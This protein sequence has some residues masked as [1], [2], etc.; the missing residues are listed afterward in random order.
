[1]EPEVPGPASRA[2]QAAF[3]R[4]A[5]RLALETAPGRVM[6]ALLAETVATVGAD[7]GVV[8]RWDVAARQLLVV[9]STLPNDSS[10]PHRP[11][12]R[13]LAG[14]VASERRPIYVQ[15][16]NGELSPDS[17]TAQ[18]G[19]RSAVCV[20]LLH[21]GRMLGT[22]SV[23]SRRPHAFGES[24]VE[25]VELLGSL[26]AAVLIGQ[27]RFRL[28]GALLAARTAQHEMNNRL[29]LTVGYAELL[30]THPDLPPSL[31][32][33][34]AEALRGAREAAEIVSRLRAISRLEETDWG[35]DSSSTIDLGRSTS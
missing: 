28:E 12:G 32:P 15:D 26:A 30:A 27:E 11:I 20:P 5:R 16:A 33:V 6:E 22:L 25:A 3:L 18:A 7:G 14:R 35:P 8:R 2:R 29:A 23:G 19:Y 21:D 17:P 9:Q 1:V 34:V 4:I 13:G 10:L 31:R 24:E